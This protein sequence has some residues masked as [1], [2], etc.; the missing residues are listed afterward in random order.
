VTLPLVIITSFF[1]MNLH[2][3]W[4]NDPH[5]MWY[6]FGLMTVSTVGILIYF[7]AKRWF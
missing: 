2:L 5:G 4:A 6:A 1:G 3:P 7:K